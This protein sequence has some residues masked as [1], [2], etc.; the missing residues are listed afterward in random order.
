VA[1]KG[2][3][4]VETRRTSGS[5]AG[6]GPDVVIEAIGLPAAFCNAV[7]KVAGTGRVAYIGYAKDR[8]AYET[9]LFCA[10]GACIPGSCNALPEDFRQVIRMLEEHGFPAQRAVG[11]IVPME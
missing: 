4:A 2:I 6:R 7:E 10:E 1:H 5:T 3:I 11:T 8:V 9:R